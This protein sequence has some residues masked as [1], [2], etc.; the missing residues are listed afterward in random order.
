MT[1]VDDGFRRLYG[2]GELRR[3][4]GGMSRAAIVDWWEPRLHNVLRPGVS[5]DEAMAMRT[6][7]I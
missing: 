7:E 5:G 2:D 4:G 3:G 1:M 6:E